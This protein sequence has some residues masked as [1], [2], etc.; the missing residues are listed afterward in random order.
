MM[1]QLGLAPMR[2]P[3]TRTSWIDLARRTRPPRLR[4]EGVGQR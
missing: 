2:I 3:A 4:R 1:N